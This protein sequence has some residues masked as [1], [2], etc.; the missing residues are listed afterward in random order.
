MFG[1]GMASHIERA[2]LLV[3]TDRLDSSRLLAT[4]L[5][6]CNSFTN[7]CFCHLLFDS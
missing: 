6:A 4:H 5:L 3:I 7:L 1:H 2:V